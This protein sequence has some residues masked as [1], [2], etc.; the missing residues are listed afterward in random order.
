M[1]GECIAIK[2]IWKQEK[3]VNTGL[4]LNLMRRL[5][6]PFEITGVSLL[7]AQHVSYYMIIMIAGEN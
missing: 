3:C 7:T 5:K 4:H 6:I 1:K 2:E